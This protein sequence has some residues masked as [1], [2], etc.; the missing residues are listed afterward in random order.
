MRTLSMIR[1]QPSIPDQWLFRSLRRSVQVS[2]WLVLCML[3]VTWS[4]CYAASWEALGP[5][6]ATVSALAIDPVNPDIVYVAG[7]SAGI[8]RSAD[9][10]GH[11][12]RTGLAET[13]VKAVIADSAAP[14]TLY[15]AATSGFYVSKDAGDTW[16]MRNEGLAR[17]YLHA[18]AVDPTDSDTIYAGAW[19][20]LF[21]TTV[22]G[23][24]WVDIGTQLGDISVVALAIDPSNPETVYAGTS[25]RGVLRSE[26]GGQSWSNVWA[27]IDDML[28]RDLVI[29]PASP[30][31]LYV[32]TNSSGVFRSYDGGDT[33][34]PVNEGLQGSAFRLAIDP[35]T[36]NTLYLGTQ[37]KGLFRSLD[38]GDAWEQ[39]STGLP[40]RQSVYAV[41][42][43]PD[44]GEVI[45]GLFSRGV[46]RRALEGSQWNEANVDLD[47]YTASSLVIDRATGEL[48]VGIET[49]GPTVF[50]SADGGST[51]T[52]SGNGMYYPAVYAMVQDP[53]EP[54]VYLTGNAGTIFRS[55]DGG[56]SWSVSDTGLDRGRVSAYE[57]LID[58]N[59]PSV[60]LAA[61]TSGIWRSSD[62]GAS[63]ELQQATSGAM[64][65]L[66]QAGN[67][68]QLVL[69]GGDRATIYRTADSGDG[70]VLSN[71]GL[72]ASASVR[73]ICFDPVHPG[74]VYAGTDRSGV[75]RSDDGGTTW[76]AFVTAAE[77]SGTYALLPIDGSTLL[78]GA[79]HAVY[80]I[81]LANA[82]WQTVGAGFD[83]EGHPELLLYDRTAGVLYAGGA[84]GLFRIDWT[85]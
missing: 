12:S 63:W 60:V 33:W 85:P 24:Q 61:M 8:F 25:D 67:D 48:L 59:E 69:A 19:G 31:T 28:I 4:P 77:L 27:G 74:T 70:W 56:M 54:N 79:T 29:D 16:E 57:L 26:D 64:H 17:T 3:L 66:A 53:V 39:W 52:P 65:T 50:R 76:T 9:G 45:A 43:R 21:K 58:S 75:F 78:A 41:A 20:G 34:R 22:A 73:A 42:V 6:G 40:S 72:P 46:Y 82:T 32:A 49:Y 1:T 23:E 44:T 2:G 10:G 37:G 36:P 15:V 68:L 71:E 7:D 83:V 11:W 51:W 18:L 62:S 55:V 30:E 13:G 35:H 84:G 5:F 81:D 38:G 80:R 14:D 47:G